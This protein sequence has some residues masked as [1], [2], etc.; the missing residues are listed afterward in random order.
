MLDRNGHVLGIA[1]ILVI[2]SANEGFNGLGF[3]I[4]GS[5]LR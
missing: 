5:V 3:A 4:A 2:S 1:T